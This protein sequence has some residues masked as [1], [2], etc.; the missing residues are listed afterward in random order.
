MTLKKEEKDVNAMCVKNRLLRRGGGRRSNDRSE[1]VEEG[2]RGV[3][4]SQVIGSK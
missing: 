3:E 4:M 2:E 1:T